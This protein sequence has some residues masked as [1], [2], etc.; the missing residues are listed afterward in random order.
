MPKANILSVI[1]ARKNSKG[2]PQ[3][4]KVIV[5][6]E[7]LIFH[8][9]KKSL[10]IPLITN[11]CLTTDDD[12]IISISKY[13][14]ITPI[15]R[16][17]KLCEDHVP[18]APVLKNAVDIVSKILDKK[19]DLVILMQPTSVTIKKETIEKGIKF[20]LEHDEYD[21]V[22]SV[23]RLQHLFWVKEN[24][25]YKLFQPE[26]VN[27]QYI[28]PIFL[29]TGAFFIIRPENIQENSFMG[30]KVYPLETSKDEAFDIDDIID[31][32]CSEAILNKKRILIAVTGSKLTGLGHV[33][34]TLSLARWLSKHEITFVTTKE[35]DLAL[36]LISECN[37]HVEKLEVWDEINSV[38]IKHRP[39]V[40]INDILDTSSSY[41]DLLVN[42][43]KKQ[44][45]LK[46]VNFEDLGEGNKYADIVIN[47]LYET[48]IN[49][50]NHYYGYKYVCI[51]DTFRYLPFKDIQ[52]I[53]SIL[54]T[55]GGT[56]HSYLTKKILPLIL[57]VL[58][59][60]QKKINLKVVIGPGFNQEYS[61]E[62]F[63]IVK[64]ISDK[65][66]S[67]T[68]EKD[69]KDMALEMWNHDLVVSSN[70]RTVYEAIS[71]G[72]PVISISQNKREDLHLFA[73][74]SP[75][76]HFLSR[77]DNE[78]KNTFIKLLKDLLTDNKHIQKLNEHAKQYGKEIRKGIKRVI[79]IIERDDDI[80]DTWS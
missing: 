15:K 11:T 55:F 42:F 34:R 4:N 14:N 48:T 5:H 76:V 46:I 43:K 66:A 71:L 25:E 69:I 51:K 10:N 80:E 3:K 50:S 22:I 2:I 27:R 67:V 9:I 20:L 19:F 61:R 78:T 74:F 6:G 37:Y 13:M 73:M 60:T 52:S 39:T 24:N 36:K 65:Y 45:S 21:T 62:L 72:I 8:A 40:I 35:N 53:N 33:Y 68:I 23:E 47:A 63:K 38:L 57:S 18:L 49:H 79:E 59:E 30:N 12:E 54:I 41:M 17:P 29:E 75:C 7:P 64:E 31:L 32:S 70:G 44:K 77:Y 16:D 58:E 28:K 56:D 1:P 26:R